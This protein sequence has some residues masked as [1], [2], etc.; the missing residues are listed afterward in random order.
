[1]ELRPDGA[2]LYERFDVRLA[3]H[4]PTGRD[5]MISCGA[6]L[7]DLELA[8]R[9]LGRRT[10][11]ALLPEPARPDLVARLE[12]YGRG[13]AT[14]QEVDRYTAIFRRR[15]YRAPFGL[16]PLPRDEVDALVRADVTPGT[17]I[18]PVHPRRESPALAELLGHA[19]RVLRGDR[20]YQ[21]ELTAWSAQFRDPLP[22]ESTLPWSGLVRADTHLPDAVTLTERLM[23]ERLLLVLTGDD[24]RADHLHAGQ[25]MQQVWLT[26]VT[27]RL[28][29][30]VLTQP[31]HLPEVRAALIER[32]DL[33]GYPQLI[34]RVGYPVTA[35]PATSTF[36]AAAERATSD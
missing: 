19:A 11:V 35:T 33:P 8:T 31:L 29:A 24:A 5:R 13:S 16:H 28:A 9:T 10:R 4:D 25:A 18:R 2:D 32:L 12:T 17:E 21:R 23:R 34:L 26:A 1:M 7:T 3:R 22:G 20:A 15:S 14:E 6:A 27:R 36:P 30:S